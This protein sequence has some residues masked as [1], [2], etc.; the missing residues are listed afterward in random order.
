MNQIG[1]VG[2]CYLELLP[3]H[4]YEMVI[5][6]DGDEFDSCEITIEQYGLICNALWED[7]EN[8]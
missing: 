8:E 3:Q 5:L 7:K 2:S 1:N 4:K 6:Q